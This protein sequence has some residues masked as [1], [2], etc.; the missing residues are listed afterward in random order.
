MS[1]DFNTVHYL[2]AL[3][4]AYGIK[5]IVSSPGTQ[6]SF[7]NA[8]VQNDNDFR[9]FSVIDERSA[10]YVAT[11]I[12]F[13]ENE[14]VVITCT[15]ATAAR[16]YM[17]ALTEA[18][19]RRIP[20]VAVTFF[21]TDTNKYNLSPQYTDRS[22]S[23][24]DVKYCSIELPVINQQDDII[25]CIIFLNAALSQA[26]YQNKPVHINCPANLDF[27]NLRKDLPTDYWKTNYYTKNF[28][29]VSKEL[30]N[31]NFAIFIGS[32][33]NFSKEEENIISDF[34]ESWNIPVFC[35]HTSQYNGKNKI[36]TAQAFY[37][38]R[39]LTK[40]PNLI[41]DIGNISGDYTYGSAFSDAKIWR[42][43]IDGLYSGRSSRP[44]E[45]FFAC[46]EKVFFNTLINTQY[47]K[48]DY[49]T[50]IKNSI[51][52][53]KYP[54]L[55]LSSAY[56]CQTLAKFIPN[57]S[58][59][60]LA[61]LN[62]LRNMN[63]FSLDSSISIN[64]NV[65]GF[66]IDGAVSTLV[67]QSVANPN[68]KCFGVIGDLAFFYDMNVLGNRHI[69]NNLRI[70]LVNNAKGAEFRLNPLLENPLSEKT[71]IL[72]AAANHN[73]G[74]AKGWVESCGF[75]YMTADTKES[76]FSQI[77]AFCNNDFDQPVLFEVFTTTNDEQ[78][79]LGL[80]R[81]FNRN[82]LEESVINVYKT[83]KKVL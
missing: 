21:D 29:D 47:K 64:C 49:Y 80:M 13:E 11:G 23:A 77:D 34:A 43:S 39:N 48:S 8:T 60:H 79:G 82:S 65:G 10:A 5:N 15:G 53:I 19:Y 1:N 28:E 33:K 20:I 17:S 72:I 58:S 35:D 71:D 62:S 38:M 36:S 22:V 74:G 54:E 73:K 7:F 70:I 55:P 32:H 78:I 14:P 56:I 59:L 31:Q 2:I 83:V 25:K 57:N 46:T 69:K 9:C 76:F 66:G 37:M 63:F 18:Y 26:V 6:N 51:E 4:K 24:N 75:K 45:K 30:E 3:L 81:S 41:I 61:I 67:G 50:K 27:S 52:Q 42:V 16:N 44:L 40:K 68:K 12:A